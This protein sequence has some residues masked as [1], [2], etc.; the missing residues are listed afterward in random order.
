MQFHSAIKNAYFFALFF[1]LTLFALNLDYVYFSVTLVV[2]ALIMVFS[3]IKNFSDPPVIFAALTAVYFIPRQILHIELPILLLAKHP[4]PLEA[5]LIMG[6]LILVAG[7]ISYLI[8]YRIF[9]RKNIYINVSLPTEHRLVLLSVFSVLL[10]LGYAG[11]ILIKIRS[12]LSFSGLQGSAQLV[13]AD[14]I[15]SYLYSIY[16]TSPIVTG[17]I[18]YCLRGRG[19]VITRLALVFLCVAASFVLARREPLLILVI[20]LLVLYKPPFDF[21][22]LLRYSFFGALIF[23]AMSIMVL[24]RMQTQLENELSVTFADFGFVYLL[25]GEF[26]VFDMYTIIISEAGGYSLPFR[27]GLDFVPR[28][29]DNFFDFDLDNRAI[30]EQL[31]SIYKPS[32]NNRVGTPFTLFGLG[33]LNFGIAGVIVFLAVFGA[34]GGITASLSRN[35]TGI[36]GYLIA[37]LGHIF[38]FYIFRNA[39][40]YFATLI[41]VKMGVVIFLVMGA[42][43]RGHLWLKNTQ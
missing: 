7:L 40:I 17:C 12:G 1:L 42:V 18:L 30:D 13:L 32:I 36:L 33:Y 25:S 14:P 15:N 41:V 16:S 20:A 19:W 11:L 26:W 29:F 5:E 35:I 28:F 39:D 6:N 3:E 24:L 37:C 2:V 43:M 23:L 21:K 9:E 10:T 38:L 4:Q 27:Q 31:A 8:F 34:L 22:K